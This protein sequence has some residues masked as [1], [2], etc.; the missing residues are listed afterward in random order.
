VRTLE[1]HGFTKAAT[2][3]GLQPIDAQRTAWADVLMLVRD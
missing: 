1:A 2:L 3:P